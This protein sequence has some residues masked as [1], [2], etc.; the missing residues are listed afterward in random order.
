MLKRHQVHGAPIYR[1][2]NA[3]QDDDRKSIGAWGPEQARST[4][5][6]EVDVAS[7]PRAARPVG[8]DP[9]AGNGPGSR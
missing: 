6:Q 5:D 9:N 3:P 4:N 8:N 2:R 7:G 1:W